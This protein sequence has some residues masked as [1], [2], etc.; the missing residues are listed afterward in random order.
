MTAAYIYTD[1]IA[2]HVHMYR[3]LHT[4]TQV[5]LFCPCCTASWEIS[6]ARG[7]GSTFS[8]LRIWQYVMD[9]RICVCKANCVA[10]VPYDMV[11]FRHFRAYRYDNTPL[12]IHVYLYS[13]CS[14]L[15][16]PQL[17]GFFFTCLRKG[18]D[19]RSH[20]CLFGHLQ[21]FSPFAESKT[22]WGAT[23]SWLFA[24]L[25][26]T[27]SMMGSAKLCRHGFHHHGASRMTHKTKMLLPSLC[28]AWVS[29]ISLLTKT[30]KNVL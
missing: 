10:F 12:I 27:A 30:T 5:K 19:I 16:L 29:R 14:F 2:C 28:F 15:L 18:N 24:G 3:C 21:A 1:M 7:Q 6:W 8:C 25:H 17:F 26:S 11:T 20:C 13:I 4:Y 23:Q 22:T 9:V